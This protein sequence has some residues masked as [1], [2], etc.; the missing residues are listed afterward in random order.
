MALVPFER[1]P[2]GVTRIHHRL[3]VCGFQSV[4]KIRQW[5]LWRSAVELAADCGD[6][7][8]AYHGSLPT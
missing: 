1:L 6:K 2:G 7:D 8:D 5:Q 4:D 3:D